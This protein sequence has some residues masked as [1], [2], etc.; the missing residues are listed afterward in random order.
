MKTLIAKTNLLHRTAAKSTVSHLV[1][2]DEEFPI[3]DESAAALIA[4]GE[5]VEATKEQ[6]ELVAK[7][8]AA[9]KALAEVAAAEAK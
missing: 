5:A 4:S 7:K 6:R 1:E 8:K 3:D 9:Q 2:I